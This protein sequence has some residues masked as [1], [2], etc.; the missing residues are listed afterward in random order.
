MRPGLGH[1][2]GRFCGGANSPPPF[3]WG[4]IEKTHPYE[5][6]LFIPRKVAV[7]PGK[8]YHGYVE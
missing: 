5:H 2:A 7:K 4:K 1:R 3:G 6:C 8:K